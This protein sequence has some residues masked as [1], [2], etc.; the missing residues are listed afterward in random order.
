MLE[1]NFYSYCIFFAALLNLSFIFYFD[2]GQ[3]KNQSFM[4]PSVLHWSYI[5]VDVLATFNPANN[6]LSKA[7]NKNTRKRC[8]IYSKLTKKQNRTRH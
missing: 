7:D 4:Y 8:E 3:Y 5:Q 2:D 6:Y 1:N